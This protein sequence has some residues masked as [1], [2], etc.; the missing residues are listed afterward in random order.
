VRDGLDLTAEIRTAQNHGYG[1]T[2]FLTEGSRVEAVAI[3]EYGPKSPAGAGSCLIRFAAVRPDSEIEVRFGQL[4]IACARL[5]ADEGLKQLVACVN[6][7]RPKAYRHLL[8]MG[9]RAQRHG[10]TMHCPNEDAYNQTA[11]YILDDLR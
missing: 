6:A 7:S 2:V 5:A 11:C 8:S 10:V 1:D 9:F 3:C 4:L